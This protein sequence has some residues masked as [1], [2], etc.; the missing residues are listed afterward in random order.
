MQIDR[1]IELF[2]GIVGVE[3]EFVCVVVVL[4]SFGNFYKLMLMSFLKIFVYFD[5]EIVIQYGL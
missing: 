4:E 5:M 2:C 3:F 1:V